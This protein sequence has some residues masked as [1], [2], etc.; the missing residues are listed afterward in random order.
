MVFVITSG[1][2]CQTYNREAEDWELAKA[3]E[4]VTVHCPPLAGD[5]GGGMAQVVMPACSREWEISPRS[6]VPAWE[7]N[8]AKSYALSYR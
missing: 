8:C 1:N 2:A 7:R 5:Q 4:D 6:Q 3:A